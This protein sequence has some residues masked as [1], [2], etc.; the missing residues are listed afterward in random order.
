MIYELRTYTL[1]LGGTREYEEI[2]KN[3]L[4]PILA[5]YGLK[6]VGYWHTEIGPLNELVHLWAFNDLNER[7]QK[8]A[9]W[10]RDP[11]RAAIV[12]RLRALVVSQSNKIMSPAEFS[13]LQ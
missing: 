6:P 9:A 11:R 7:Q 5:E 8:W 13:P 3:E 10:G 2:T 4:L 12:P 1:V